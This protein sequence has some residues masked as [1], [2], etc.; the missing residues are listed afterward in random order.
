MVP[1]ANL[2][3][4]CIV[5]QLV[6]LGVRGWGSGGVSSSRDEFPSVGIWREPG[7]WISHLFSVCG[8]LQCVLA[9]ENFPEMSPVSMYLDMS[10]K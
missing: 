6:A 10:S 1:E 8:L 7:W 4:K 5:G 3:W 9:S 2:I